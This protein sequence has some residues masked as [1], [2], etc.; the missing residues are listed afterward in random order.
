MAFSTFSYD[1]LSLAKNAHGAPEAP[2]CSCCRILGS[3]ADQGERKSI[4]DSG[5]EERQASQK[6][7]V[8]KDE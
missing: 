8:L 4:C 7:R 5:K 6:K 3:S 1:Y 2:S